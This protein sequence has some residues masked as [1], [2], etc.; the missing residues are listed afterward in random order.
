M[1]KR[2]LLASAL[3]AAAMTPALAQTPVKIFFDRGRGPSAR[4]AA[5]AGGP[6]PRPGDRRSG[7]PAGGLVFVVEQGRVIDMIP[8][9]EL[10]ANIDKLHTY[11]GV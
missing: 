11:L 9:A 4:A 5:G 3:C 6:A 7:P 10:D 8:N 2:L 1:L